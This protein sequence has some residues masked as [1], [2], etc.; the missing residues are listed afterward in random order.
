MIKRVDAKSTT[1]YFLGPT[2]L[3][4]PIYLQL[5]HINQRAN[6][7]LRIFLK[8]SK[9]ISKSWNSYFTYLWTNLG[10]IPICVLETTAQC[11]R[12]KDCFL[13]IFFLSYFTTKKKAFA[14]P[15][16]YLWSGVSGTYLTVEKRAKRI[17]D[18]TV[19]TTFLFFSMRSFLF[20]IRH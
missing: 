1:S 2:F 18:I 7:H 15:P 20:D 12:D 4:T 10:P 5:I 6:I 14:P 19:E 11:V 9:S 8:V 16:P 13:F 3:G 17:P